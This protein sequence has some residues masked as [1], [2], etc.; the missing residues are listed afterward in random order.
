MYKAK[1]PKTAAASAEP[2]A[3][4]LKMRSGAVPSSFDMDSVGMQPESM[5]PKEHI[6]FSEVRCFFSGSPVGGLSTLPSLGD[7]KPQTFVPLQQH[8]PYSIPLGVQEGTSA[9]EGGP[10]WSRHCSPWTA[11]TWKRWMGILRGSLKIF[12]KRTVYDGNWSSFDPLWQGSKGFW[13]SKIT[14]RVLAYVFCSC[15]PDEGRLC[16]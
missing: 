10:T 11:R 6:S 4:L 3:Q 14:P 2:Q 5:D 7:G 8:H 1:G 12:L 9:T 16:A 13:C 15:F